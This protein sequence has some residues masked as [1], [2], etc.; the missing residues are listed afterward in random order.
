[1]QSKYDDSKA[2]ETQY[3]LITTTNPWIPGTNK[4]EPFYTPIVLT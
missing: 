3:Q 1:M 4:T 2:Y